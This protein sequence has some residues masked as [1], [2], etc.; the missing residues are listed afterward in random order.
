[1]LTYA[2]HYDKC[3]QNASFE[4]SGPSPYSSVYDLSLDTSFLN[5]DRHSKPKARDGKLIS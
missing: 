2:Q 4:S 1:M 3:R 5:V